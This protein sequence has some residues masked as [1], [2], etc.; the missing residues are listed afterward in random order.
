MYPHIKLSFESAIQAIHTLHDLSHFIG[1]I[2]LKYHEILARVIGEGSYN[3][4]YP[5]DPITDFNEMYGETKTGRRI[6]IVNT[7]AKKLYFK[8]RNWFPH[9]QSNGPI[10]QSCDFIL[11]VKHSEDFTR[12][13]SIMIDWDVIPQFLGFD[14]NRDMWHTY[15]SKA[16]I[17]ESEILL[18]ES[19]YRKFLP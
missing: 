5:D 16:F 7:T 19:D 4:K 6:L 2:K 1:P 10:F 3:M 13:S 14:W 8:D 15:L 18:P 9:P 11:I 12:F 17:N